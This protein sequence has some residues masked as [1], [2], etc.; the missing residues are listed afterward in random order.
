MDVFAACLFLLNADHPLSLI[1]AF[2]LLYEECDRGVEG[3][4]EATDNAQE[5]M[6]AAR[7]EH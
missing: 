6:L 7:Q 3:K 5:R 2:G 4:E 1:Y